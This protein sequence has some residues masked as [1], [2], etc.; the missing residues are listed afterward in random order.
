MTERH[1][2]IGNKTK[3]TK[4]IAPTREPLTNA[5]NGNQIMEGGERKNLNGSI[6]FSHVQSITWGVRMRGFAHEMTR[7]MLVA[8]MQHTNDGAAV[9][10]AQSEHEKKIGMLRG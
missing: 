1:V 8:T 2:L 6:T 4:V 3:R 10:G 9:N 5:K 7:N